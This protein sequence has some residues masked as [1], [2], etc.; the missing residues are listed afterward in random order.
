[1]PTRY[2]SP[3][4]S[5]PRAADA[6]AAAAAMLGASANAA[7]ASYVTRPDLRPTTVDVTT[8]AVGTSPGYVFVT[9]KG[10]GIDSGAEIFDDS[11]QLVWFRPAARK[12]TSVLNLKPQTYQGRPVATESAMSSAR[13]DL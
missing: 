10:G 12:G 7:T 9:P 2:L 11:G 3:V 13:K 6:A 8:P 5:V 1:M 4:R